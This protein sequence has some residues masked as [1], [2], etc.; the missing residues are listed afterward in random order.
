MS[1]QL[2]RECPSILSSNIMKATTISTVIIATLV[3]SI[4][5][6][7]ADGAIQPAYAAEGME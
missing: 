7:A 4:A 1:N 2:I 3:L 5:M 6:I